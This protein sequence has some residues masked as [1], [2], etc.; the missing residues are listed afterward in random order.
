MEKTFTHRTACG[1]HIR[2]DGRGIGT[3][4]SY[5][6]GDAVRGEGTRVDVDLLV[7]NDQERESRI[8]SVQDRAALCARAAKK[9]GQEKLNRE[10]GQDRGEGRGFRNGRESLR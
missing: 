10:E 4:R 7:T 2:M 6:G 1:S 9:G 5:E 8:C 3:Q